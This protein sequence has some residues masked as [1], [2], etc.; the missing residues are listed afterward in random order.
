[1]KFKYIEV[2]ILL[3]LTIIETG[4]VTYQCRMRFEMLSISQ[5]PL[6]ASTFD[7]LKQSACFKFTFYIVK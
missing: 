2:T 1:M 7:H 5:V 6:L 3:S 4:N